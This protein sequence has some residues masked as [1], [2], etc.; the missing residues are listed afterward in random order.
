MKKLVVLFLAVIMLLQCACSAVPNT[1][2]GAGD[3][4][5]SSDDVAVSNL[6]AES[7]YIGRLDAVDWAYVRGGDHKNKTYA[8]LRPAKDRLE[9]KCNDASNIE[10]DTSYSRQFL[11]QFDAYEIKDKLDSFNT[12]KLT[13]NWAYGD[14]NGDSFSVY[15]ISGNVDLQTVTWSNRP[16]GELV[17]EGYSIQSLTPANLAA[18][19]K[20]AINENGGLL[21]L[22]FV[23]EI[24]TA[25]EGQLKCSGT[26][27]PF[28][29]L[30]SSADEG[31]AY[32]YNLVDDEAANKAIWD[33][34]KNVYDSWYER[35]QLLLAKKES[36]P[37]INLIESDAA[38]YNMKVSTFGTNG[39]RT[40]VVR[41]T[42]TVGAMTDLA[43][44]VD[45][46][47]EI[48]VDVYGGI[49]DPMMRQEATGNFYTTKIGDR[50]WMIDP[51]GY[52]CYL[53]A[54]SGITYEYSTGS[55]NQLP[56]VMEKYGSKEK[57]GI[58][59][60]RHVV[61]DLY[62]N[63]STTKVE[64]VTGVEQGIFRQVA[65]G[66]FAGGYGSKIGV[67]ASKGGS[68][69][70][71]NNN[72]MPVFDPDFET[73]SD[74]RAKSVTAPYIGDPMLIGYTTDNE[75]PMQADML[76]NYLNVDPSLPVNHYSYACAWTWL[77]NMTG[78][79]EFE[80]STITSELKELFRGFVWDRYYNVVCAAVRKYD[81]DHM[82]LGTR[83]LTGVKNAEWVLR[84]AS[85]YLDA[86]TIN[87]YNAWE[88]KVVDI[89]QMCTYG[90]LP[91]IV[92]EFYA[93]AKENE[94]NLAH[95]DT[96][97]GWLVQT[98]NDRGYFYQNFTLRLLEC[99]NVI[100]WHWFQYL[101]CD[102][103]GKQTDVS[104]KDS[105]KGIMSNTHK[106]YTD[107]TEKM[108]EINKNVYHLIEYFDTKYAK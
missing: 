18:Y 25:S 91:I 104:S 71:H 89:Q 50:W 4:V 77:I 32:I 107:L 14:T 26:N 9:F 35:Y 82:L 88:P 58:S 30:S 45:I 73:Y 37:V 62:F 95:T 83:F 76:I 100:G 19:V 13:I 65:I 33:Y 66:G 72:T 8:E 64:E 3:S 105:N 80:Q 39:D 60:T 93:K 38:H 63:L 97:A 44:Y 42:R 46:N 12:A 54:L 10:A 47:K 7:V 55:P 40:E 74:E 43:D 2:V 5:L 68:T 70:F 31:A 69:T 6:E 79:E 96:S 75:L 87:W 81:P 101:D 92:T 15:Y 59:A 51:L 20:R 106:E 84:F 27:I 36:D 53:R 56:A 94:G 34:A 16:M 98:Q 61:D 17:E 103:A 22:R 28:I 85:L 11:L 41:D 57:W 102:P 29:T 48:E 49:V 78:S 108:V 52:P 99:K 21:T 1:E 24:K 67:N 90:Q 23:P 86:I